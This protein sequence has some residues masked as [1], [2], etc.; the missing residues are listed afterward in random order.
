MKRI[1]IR[2]HGRGGQGAVTAAIIVAQA[3]IFEGKYAQAYPEFGAERRGAP[4]RAYNRVSDEPIYTRAPIL[5]PDVVVV[6]DSSLPKEL[7]MEGLKSGGYLVMNTKKSI[8]EVKQYIGR[9]DIKIAVVDAT[10]I[11]L[12]TLGIPI[13]NTAMVGA[14]VKVLPIVK[15]ERVEEAI[16]E[17]FSGRLAEVNIQAVRKAYES[18]K[19]LSQ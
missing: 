7:Y 8:D 14:L 13:V 2:W 17:N 4:V 16:R 12:E 6:L 15:I 1:E 9:N 19:V 10:R 11:A 3:A 5:T 18:V